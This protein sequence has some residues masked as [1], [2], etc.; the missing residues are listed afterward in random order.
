[1][2]TSCSTALCRVSNEQ[3]NTTQS[4]WCGFLIIPKN[5]KTQLTSI[6]TKFNKGWNEGMNNKEFNREICFT[7]Y[8]SWLKQTKQIR[9]MYDDRVALDYLLAI[10]D[11]ACYEIEPTDPFVQMMLMSIREQIDAS[12]NRRAG[13]FNRENTAQTK[14]I[15]DY[16][17]EHPDA[18]QDAISKALGISKG[19]VNKV[20]KDLPKDNRDID[21]GNSNNNDNNNSN[22]NNNSNDR[23]CDHTKTQ[24]KIDEILANIEMYQDLI[25]KVQSMCLKGNNFD[26]IQKETKLGKGVIFDIVNH[27]EKYEVAIKEYRKNQ[28]EIEIEKQ[29]AERMKPLTKEQYERFEKWVNSKYPKDEGVGY[30]ESFDEV[31]DVWNHNFNGHIMHSRVVSLDDGVPATEYYSVRDYDTYDI[32]LMLDIITKYQPYDNK[33][34]IVDEI[35]KNN[36]NRSYLDLFDEEEI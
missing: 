34:D 4:I 8:S 25:K 26:I 29:R 7:C 30:S 22:I 35:E 9:E 33:N 10:G 27:K 5:C 15:L 31:M 16:Y 19:K 18:S 12:Q 3:T 36:P 6:T 13:G 1:M 20:L 14:A 17:K 28:T 21:N 11:Y 23:D 24:E 2:I 32:D